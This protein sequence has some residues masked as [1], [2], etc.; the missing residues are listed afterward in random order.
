MS[1]E[2]LGRFL[3]Q[4]AGNEDL[5]ERIGEEIDGDA[6]IALGAEYGC[7]FTDVDLLL[8]LEHADLSEEE[9]EAVA[10]GT[11]MAASNRK[12]R[13]SGLSGFTITEVGQP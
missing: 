4:I 8:Y 3:E 5:Q 13:Y 10:G 6:L 9:L 12:I 7:E 2:N 11:T 1:K